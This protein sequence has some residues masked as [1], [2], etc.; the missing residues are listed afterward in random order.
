MVTAFLVMLRCATDDIPLFLAD[1]ERSAG[2]VASAITPAK[3]WSLIKASKWSSYSQPITVAVVTFRDGVAVHERQF[4]D[5]Q[6]TG[7]TWPDEA[8]A[9]LPVDMMPPFIRWMHHQ[10]L[11]RV[12]HM[13]GNSWAVVSDGHREGDASTEVTHG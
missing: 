8:S 13:G 2:E 10:G 11:G 4:I 1:D 6:G 7:W 9:P 5:C 3:A 12:H